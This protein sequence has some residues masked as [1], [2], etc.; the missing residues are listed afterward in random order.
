MVVIEWFRPIG[1]IAMDKKAVLL[2]QPFFNKN[3]KS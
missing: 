1:L 2:E 3:Y